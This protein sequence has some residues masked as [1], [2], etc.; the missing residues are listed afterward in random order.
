MLKSLGALAVAPLIA[1][2]EVPPDHVRFSHVNYGLRPDG[3]LGSA[4]QWRDRTWWIGERARLRWTDTNGVAYQPDLDWIE[5]PYPITQLAPDR[6]RLW[7]LT[8]RGWFYF[9]YDGNPSDDTA[10]VVFALAT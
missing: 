1:T 10:K 7:L 6:D 3:Q 8:P 4:V 2:N 5:T 9:T